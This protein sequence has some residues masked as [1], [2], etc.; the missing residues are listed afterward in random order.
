MCTTDLLKLLLHAADILKYF[1][2]NTASLS[3]NFNVALRINQEVF[4]LQ[5]AVDDLKSM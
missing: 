1:R 2:E 5:I 3:T 4:W